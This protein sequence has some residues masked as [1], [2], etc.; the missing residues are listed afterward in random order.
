M[1]S[2]NPL[3]S[4]ENANPVLVQLN[5]ILAEM[6]V[7]TA[8]AVATIMFHQPVSLSTH[9]MFHTSFPEGIY[10]K[11]SYNCSRA[12]MPQISV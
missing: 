6:K 5:P 2:D 7:A 1:H 8:N 10:S 4:S 3:F 11:S 12:T 9:A